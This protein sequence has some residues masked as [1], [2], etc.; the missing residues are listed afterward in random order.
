MRKVIF[1][2]DNTMGLWTKEIDDGLALFYLLGRPDID[3]LG[4]TTT[5]GNGTIEGV[6]QSTSKL[7]DDLYL[8]DLPVLRG[9]DQRGAGPTEAAEFLAG[10]AAE[11]PGQI[12]L[13][14]T[15]PLGNLR[16]AQ[17]IDRNF[18]ANLKSISC[19]GGYLRPLK[20][21]RRVV[22]ELNLSADPEAAHGFGGERGVHRPA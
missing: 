5:F 18:L 12:D 22:N 3:L 14:A 20:V 15:G 13:L 8:V 7:A 21:G 4:I 11:H 10:M 9:A 2:C 16:G 6:F 1:D 17:Q 19:M